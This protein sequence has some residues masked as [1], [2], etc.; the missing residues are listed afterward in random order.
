M[1][2]NIKIQKNCEF[3]GL[4]FTAKT[5]VTRFCS[6][7]CNSRFYKQAIRNEKI[8]LAQA[9]SKMAEDVSIQNKDPTPEYL[10]INEAAKIMRISRSTLYRLIQGKKFKTKKVLSRTIISKEDIKSFFAKL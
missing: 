5:L 2:S 1:S 8:A 6:H 9:A 7:R 10:D 4:E 3:C